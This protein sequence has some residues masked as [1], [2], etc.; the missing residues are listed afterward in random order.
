M[1]SRVRRSRQHRRH[2]RRVPSSYDLGGPNDTLF[3]GETVEA[4]R[5]EVHAE[6][7]LRASARAARDPLV[8]FVTNEVLTPVLHPRDHRRGISFMPQTAPRLRET[9]LGTESSSSERGSLTLGEGES[10]RCQLHPV[11]T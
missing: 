10:S 11:F 1:R 2:E 3:E 9:T 7:V 6:F 4:P 5:V 8:H